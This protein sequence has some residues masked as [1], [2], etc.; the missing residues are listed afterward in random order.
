MTEQTTPGDQADFVPLFSKDEA[1]KKTN[2]LDA[3]GQ[4][5]CVQPPPS[6]RKKIG[7][8][9]P[10]SIFFLRG[11]GSCTQAI[12]WLKTRSPKTTEKLI[13][14]NAYCFFITMFGLAIPAFFRFTNVTELMQQ[15]E[16]YIIYNL[17]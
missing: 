16:Y 9:A 13:Q 12:G 4:L 17:I 2:V 11:G 15:S 1:I 14:S 5:A 10:S 6:L 7:E 8:G 3:S